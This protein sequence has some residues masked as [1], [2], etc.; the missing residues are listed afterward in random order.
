[1]GLNP[2]NSSL[3]KLAKTMRLIV[4]DLDGTLL[5]PDDSV[6]APTVKAALGLEEKRIAFTLCSGRIYA[7]LE[8]Y[9][10][11]F[12]V[13]K[14]VI[15]AN[16]AAIIDPVTKNTLYEKP[17]SP[18]SAADLLRFCQSRAIDYCVMTAD[19]CYF[20]PGSARIPRILSYNNLASGLD[21]AT[22]PIKYYRT[23]QLT[24]P[25]HKIA[26]TENLAGESDLIVSYVRE[27]SDL[28]FTTSSKRFIDVTS[29][30]VSKGNA[31]LHL[32]EILAIPCPNIC[33]FGDYDNDISMFK[34][35]GLSFAMAN[36]LENVKAA[37]TATTD[38]NRADGVARALA[39]YF[40]GK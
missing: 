21:L 7:M 31:L 25:I 33:S 12:A 23:G 35:S 18:E 30:G 19:G 14:P 37:A 22:V 4:S 5:L 26:I 10:K 11:I 27:N 28:S 29:R 2:K 39:M 38:S 36:S 3:A 32:A 20:S 9:I 15:T 34:V 6:T 40:L 17:I 8:Y 24:K 13:T 1:M 16:G